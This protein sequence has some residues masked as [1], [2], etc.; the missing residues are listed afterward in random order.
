MES[1]GLQLCG[2]QKVHPGR[3]F[4]PPIACIRPILGVKPRAGSLRF[5]GSSRGES[6]TGQSVRQGKED[7]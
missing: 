2:G 7:S 5:F 3:L 4:L 1:S 6:A